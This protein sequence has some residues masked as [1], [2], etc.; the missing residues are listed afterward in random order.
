MKHLYYP[1]GG[2]A[3]MLCEAGHNRNTN[4]VAGVLSYMVNRGLI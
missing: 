3:G 1:E 2:R 4:P